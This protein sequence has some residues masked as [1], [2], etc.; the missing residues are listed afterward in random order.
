MSR[1]IEQQ[2]GSIFKMH[3][4]IMIPATAPDEALFLEKGNEGHRNPVPIANDTACASLMPVPIV[5][6]ADIDIDRRTESV[7]A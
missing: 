4:V 2:F 7:H 6:I 3:G 5:G 1:P